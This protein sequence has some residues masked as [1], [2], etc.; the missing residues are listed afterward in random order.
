LIVWGVLVFII[1]QTMTEVFCPLELDITKIPAKSSKEKEKK[2]E[3][4]VTI[5]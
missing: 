5:Y 2:R 4:K 1:K 3:K